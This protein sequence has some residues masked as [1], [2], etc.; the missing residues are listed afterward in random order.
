MTDKSAAEKALD[1]IAATCGC[2]A[3]EYPGQVVRDVRALHGGLAAL[4]DA[5]ETDPEVPLLRHGRAVP[6]LAHARRLVG[7]RRD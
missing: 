7:R 2:P 5:I 1:D 6:A 3:W 4:V